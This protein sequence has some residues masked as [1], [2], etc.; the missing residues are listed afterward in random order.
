LRRFGF[1]G[2]QR[3]LAAPDVSGKYYLVATSGSRTTRT[4]LGFDPKKPTPAI[5]VIFREAVKSVWQ[6]LNYVWTKL[7]YVITTLIGFGAGIATKR[8]D[9]KRAL[10][11]SLG[12]LAVAQAAVMVQYENLNLLLDEW[13]NTAPGAPRRGELRQQW[14]D[15]IA[16]LKRSLEEFDAARPDAAVLFPLRGA[17]G[18]QQLINL[19]TATEQIRGLLG[20]Q[21]DAFGNLSNAARQVKLRPFQDL[22]ANPLVNG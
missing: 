20:E 9:N 3:A 5:H 1:V 14:P 18:Q 22:R 2:A 6:Y 8:W 15:V 7:D 10:R 16:T 4:D 21:L 11:I 17:E 13:L 12:R 19:K